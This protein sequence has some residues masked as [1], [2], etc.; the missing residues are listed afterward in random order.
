MTL[1]ENNSQDKKKGETEYKEIY[2]QLSA[3][4]ESLDQTVSAH[5]EKQ[6]MDFL[7]AYR[8]RRFLIIFIE[9]HAKGSKRSGTT[10]EATQ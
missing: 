2:S 4:I 6:E 3:V 10:Q 1:S 8:V 5:V 9:T 7:V